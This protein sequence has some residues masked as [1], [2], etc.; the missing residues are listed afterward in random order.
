MVEDHNGDVPQSLK[1]RQMIALD[2]GALI[3][4]LRTVPATGEST[5]AP[6]LTGEIAERIARGDYHSAADEVAHYAQNPSPALGEAHRLGRY[7]AMAMCTGCHGARMDGV[8]EFGGPV[9]PAAEYND[10]ELRR[11]LA[12][13]VP[14][15]G[16]SIRMHGP[17]GL[18]NSELTA[19][20]AYTRAVAELQAR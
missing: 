12:E 16:R 19:L 1:D 2:M 11:F 8:G 15:D 7:I 13:G 14:R 3:A 10:A 9:A 17:M 18:A 4:F 5:P 6:K 20:A